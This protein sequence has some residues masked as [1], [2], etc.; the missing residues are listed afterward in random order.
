MQDSLKDQTIS[1]V[2]WSALQ[3][4]GTMGISFISNIILA[5]LLSPDDYGCLGLLAIFI[6]VSN[7]FIYGGFVT[8]LIQ[9]QSPTQTDYSTVFYWNIATSVLFYIIL[10]IE[11]FSDCF[12]VLKNTWSHCTEKYHP[13]NGHLPADAGLPALRDTGAGPG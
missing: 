3:R 2:L 6:A 1:G 8:A 13:K 7:V 10:Y 9:K 4:F 5:R 12:C 11:I